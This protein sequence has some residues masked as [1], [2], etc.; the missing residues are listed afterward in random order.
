MGNYC[1]GH[2]DSDDDDDDDAAEYITVETG[3][4]LQEIELRRESSH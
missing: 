4:G 3:G 2:S 1:H